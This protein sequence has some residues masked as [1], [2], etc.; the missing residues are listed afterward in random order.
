MLCNLAVRRASESDED[1]PLSLKISGKHA[2]GNAGGSLSDE[3]RYPTPQSLLSA[4]SELHVPP[5]VLSRA[6]SAIQSDEAVRLWQDVGTDVP[7]D[8]PLLCGNGF[9]LESQER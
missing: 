4:L 1:F 8:F 9:C 7:I 2:L 6:D 3:A 5:E